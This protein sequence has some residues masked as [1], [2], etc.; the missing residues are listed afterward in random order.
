M[1]HTTTFPWLWGLT[2]DKLGRTAEGKGR[3]LT[4]TSQFKEETSDMLNLELI[5]VWCWHLDTSDSG[6]EITR[7]FWNVVLEK[8]EADQLNRSY[9]KWSS[10]TYSHERQVHRTC[11]KRRKSTW[12]CHIWP[13]KCFL[14]HVIGGTIENTGIRGITRK[15]LMDNLKE[16]R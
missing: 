3:W 16:T 7:K 4:N 14:K 6:S 2:H 10:I 1:V 9:E 5:F 11:S 15:Q 8:D 12:I 13:R